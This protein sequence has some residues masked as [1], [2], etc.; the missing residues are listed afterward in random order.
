MEWG[1]GRLFDQGAAQLFQQLV[2]EARIM[3]CASVAL[4]EERRHRPH[5]EASS[6][7]M[8]HNVDIP[9]SGHPFA[10]VSGGVR[11]HF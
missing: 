2:K 4:K 10:S 8:P 9:C 5:G 1:R 3:R 11:R 6:M 7:L